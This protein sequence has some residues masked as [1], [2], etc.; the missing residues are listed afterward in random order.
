M[1]RVPRADP[2][3]DGIADPAQRGRRITVSGASAAAVA[4]VPEA[5]LWRLVPTIAVGLA[6]AATLYSVFRVFEGGI[7]FRPLF[8]IALLFIV[9]AGV[10]PVQLGII[11]TLHNMERRAARQRLGGGT[12]VWCGYGRRAAGVPIGESPV[13]GGDPPRLERSEDAMCPECGST[14]E[15]NLDRFDRFTNRR[16]VQAAIVSGLS[17]ALGCG[18]AEAWLLLDTAAFRQEAAAAT[19]AG[20]AG[21]YARPRWWPNGWA[22]LH[23]DADSGLVTTLIGR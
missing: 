3:H 14:L 15:G 10:G 12:C 11:F 20:S 21:D 17:I 18:A 13:A 5:R 9:T 22:R 6:G 19:L 4:H 8:A 16:L 7:G 2:E 1:T 23:W